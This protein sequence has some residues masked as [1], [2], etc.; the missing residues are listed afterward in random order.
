MF[1]IENSKT[2]IYNTTEQKGEHILKRNGKIWGKTPQELTT[3]A[4][5]RVS[6]LIGI[7]MSSHMNWSR[8]IQIPTLCDHGGSSDM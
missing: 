4:L 6:S 3:D 7:K 8:E 2:R 1:Y 5:T